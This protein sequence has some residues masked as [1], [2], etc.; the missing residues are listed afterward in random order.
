MILSLYVNQEMARIEKISGNAVIVF[1][2]IKQ[3]MAL[4]YIDITFVNNERYTVLYHNMI[5]KQIPIFITSKRTLS[6]AIQELKEADLLKYAGNNM[7][8]AYTFTDKAMS[9]ITRNNGNGSGDV[10]LDANKVRKKPLFELSKLTKIPDLKK[11]Y[12]ILLR[13]HCLSICEKENI[14]QEEFEKFIDYHSSKGNKF[15]NYIRAFGSWVRNYKKFNEP[16]KRV[17]GQAV[18]L[19]DIEH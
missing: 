13:E 2:A 4:K 6:R 15:V 12:Y 1:D 11:E 3:L 10:S 17:A 16:K 7:A 8:P 14:P 18:L 9:Y 5:L 19:D